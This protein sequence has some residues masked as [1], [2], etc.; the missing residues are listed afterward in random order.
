MVAQ[1]Y[2]EGVIAAADTVLSHTSDDRLERHAKYAKATA[3]RQAGRNDEA[4]AIYVQL[5]GDVSSSEGA[6]SA[7]RVIAAAYSA[8]DNARVGEWVYAFADR[9]TPHPSWLGQGFLV[10]GDVYAGKGDAFQARATYQSVVD[11][12]PNTTDGVVDEAK[13]R[14]AEL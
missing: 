2:G 5:S 10:F 11:G 8:G 4:V 9:N 12:Y 7:Y 3:L 13:A 6:E 1:G 14:I